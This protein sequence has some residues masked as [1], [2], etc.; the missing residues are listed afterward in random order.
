MV[1]LG[2]RKSKDTNGDGLRDRG[3]GKGRKVT[4]RTDPTQATKDRYGRLLAY[5]RTSVDLQAA[6]LRRGW[7]AVYIYA[8]KPFQRTAQYQGV[9]AGAKTA[10]RGVWGRCG[11]NF[12]L[13]S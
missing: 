13:T 8:N 11:G 3:R 12:Q 9:E 5:A 4:L 7:A 2:F 1:R 10:T 6:Q